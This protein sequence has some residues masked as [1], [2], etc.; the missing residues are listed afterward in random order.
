MRF[1]K[2][3]VGIAALLLMVG[4]M[5]GAGAASTTDQTP[6]ASSVDAKDTL[7]QSDRLLQQDNGTGGGDDGGDNGGS[8]DGDDGSDD[9]GSGDDGAGGGGDGGSGDGSGDMPDGG[10]DSGHAI[11]QPLNNLL[12]FL[13]DA[14]ELLGLII[15]AV[16]VTVY[17]TGTGGNRSQIGLALSIKGAFLFVLSLVWPLLQATLESFAVGAVSVGSLFSELVEWLILLSPV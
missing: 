15:L 11:L 12:V 6:A 4:L 16:G 8:D 1:A 2:P 5:I 9:G 7:T 17:S 13:W 14:A 10:T 3:V